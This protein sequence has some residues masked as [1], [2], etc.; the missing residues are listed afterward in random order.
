MLQEA[1]FPVT[2]V[3]A[4]GVP[5]NED[6]SDLTTREIDDTGYK[7]I[8][9]EDTGSILSCMTDDY[10]LVKN[11]TI[12]NY[13]NPV[14][15]KNKGVLK[16]VRLFSG[17][18][19]TTMT[20]QFPKQKVHIGPNDNIS[21]EIIIR[22]SYDGTV[23]VNILAGAFRLICTNGMVIGV[24]LDNYKNKHSVYNIELDQLEQ[25]IVDTIEKTKYMFEDEFPTLIETE[26][27]EKHIINFIKMFPVQANTI[28]T[29]RLIL[30]KPKTFWDLFNVGTNVLTHNM[31]R[32]A[33]STHQVESSLY[34][35]IKKWA[36]T[37][38][39]SA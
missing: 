23:G 29:Q 15:K 31:N 36:T 26:I 8:M 18:A 30:D 38:I 14:I 7:F 19:K 5:F 12:I 27:K 25:S 11:E 20:W 28:I 2:E 17:G 39:A 37:E 6:T 33:E 4:I 10:R 9:R 22:N 16:E 21:P 24:V 35:T 3:P 13:A 1:M 34:P 32:N